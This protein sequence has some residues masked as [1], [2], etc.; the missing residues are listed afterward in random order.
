LSYT[1]SPA[2]HLKEE[3]LGRY[4]AAAFEEG[5]YLQVE[6]AGIT[7]RGIANPHAAAFLAFMTGPGFQDAIALGNWM[8]PAGRTSGPLDP[9]FDQ[10]VRPSRALQLPA[11]D[12]ADNRKAWIDEWL[13]A[14]R[15]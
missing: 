8:Y 14:M 13:R 10:L 11:A 3:G 5:H 12:I 15:R 2:Y 6:I 1:T 9:V 4:R 7:H